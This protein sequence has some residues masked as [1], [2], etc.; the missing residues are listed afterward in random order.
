MAGGGDDSTPTM[1]KS[2]GHIR[3]GGTGKG[4]TLEGEQGRLHPTRRQLP[5][6]DAVTADESLD[7]QGCR[8]ERWGMSGCLLAD[9]FF[10]TAYWLFTATKKATRQVTSSA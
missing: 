8:V 6:V 7:G 4:I 1:R 5:Q 9:G 2:T 3:Q 10:S